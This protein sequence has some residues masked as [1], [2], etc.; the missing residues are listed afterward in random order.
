[1]TELISVQGNE[2]TIGY[3]DGQ[4]IRTVATALWLLDNYEN[5]AESAYNGVNQHKKERKTLKVP[6]RVFQ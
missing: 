6:Y 3:G 5:D 2:I 4:R 1:M